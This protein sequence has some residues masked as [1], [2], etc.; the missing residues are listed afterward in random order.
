MSIE[1]QIYYLRS[2]AAIEIRDCDL[3]EHEIE[4]QMAIEESANTIEELY[5]KQSE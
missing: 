4:F 1:E 5:K 3:G 2:L